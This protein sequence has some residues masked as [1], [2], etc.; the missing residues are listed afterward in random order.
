MSER[1]M[2]NASICMRVNSFVEALINIVRKLRITSGSK[3]IVWKFYGD[4]TFR[5]K[6]YYW[7]N[8]A[9]RAMK[10]I[11]GEGSIKLFF[12]SLISFELHFNSRM[13]YIFRHF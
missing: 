11:V 13:L 6:S 2:L 7:K 5:E 1:E 8:S 12:C 4:P 9:T 3:K 10:Y